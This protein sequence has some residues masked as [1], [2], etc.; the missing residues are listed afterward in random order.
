MK[1]CHT[2]LL[3]LA[4]LLCACGTRPYPPSLLTADSLASVRPDSAL[5]LL[6][7]LAADTVHMPL[8]HRMYYRL[9][10]IKAADKAFLPHTSDSLIRP[11]LQYYIEQG[12]KQ[13]LPEVY[14][15]TGR[16][17]YDLGNAPQAL[18]YFIQAQNALEH[19]EN[20]ALSNKIYGQMGYI[21]LFQGLYAE[22]LQAFQKSYQCDVA[23]KDS[24]GMIYSYRDIANCYRAIEKKTLHSVIFRKQLT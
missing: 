2:Y 20:L 22:A 11:V 8:H 21:L 13:R 3:L 16:V 5:A 6:Q 23:L 17:Y 1:K 18:D 7:H 14:Y 10:C 9:L 12:D 15:Y 19:N 4:L 24:I